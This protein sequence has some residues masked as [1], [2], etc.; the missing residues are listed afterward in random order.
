MSTSGVDKSNGTWVFESDNNAL[1]TVAALVM[2]LGG[3]VEITQTDIDAVAYNILVEEE[4]DSGL[5][6]VIQHKTTNN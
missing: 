6:L 2:K 4:T 5:S 1:L 3:S